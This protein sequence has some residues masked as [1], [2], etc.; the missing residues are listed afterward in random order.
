MFL[1][2]FGT[3]FGSDFYLQLNAFKICDAKLSRFSFIETSSLHLSFKLIRKGNELIFTHS[4]CF[5]G[6]FDFLDKLVFIFKP[7]RFEVDGLCSYILIYYSHK[8]VLFQWFALK[9]N[10]NGDNSS[11]P[12]IVNDQIISNCFCK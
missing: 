12:L 8:K 11:I 10:V 1:S 9:L 3:Q 2:N 7:L 6:C 4:D 5:S